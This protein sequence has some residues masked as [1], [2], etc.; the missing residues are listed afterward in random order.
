MSR[1]PLLP[2]RPQRPHQEGI[3]GRGRHGHQED[4]EEMAPFH[5]QC[6]EEKDEGEGRGLDEQDAQWVSPIHNG[7][8]T[9]WVCLRVWRPPDLGDSL[10]KR[11]EIGTFQKRRQTPDNRQ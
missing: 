8:L 6:G 3:D 7:S 11:V 9:R 1:L 2:Q 4:L 10:A 5:D